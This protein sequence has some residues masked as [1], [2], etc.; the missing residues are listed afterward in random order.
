MLFQDYTDYLSKNGSN[1]AEASFQISDEFNLRQVLYEMVMNNP[2]FLCEEFA[3]QIQDKK[4]LSDYLSLVGR[5]LEEEPVKTQIVLDFV[6]QKLNKRLPMVYFIEKQEKDRPKKVKSKKEKKLSF[7]RKWNTKS[8]AGENFLGNFSLSV[9]SL[10]ME[11]RKLIQGKKKY[12]LNK[13]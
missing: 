2:E 10:I 12:I 9:D 4:L 5:C 13:K 8:S 7:I 11:E 1:L 6:Y 3:S